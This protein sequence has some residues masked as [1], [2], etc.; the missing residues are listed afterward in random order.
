MTIEQQLN[1][2]W[3]QAV[4]NVESNAGNYFYDKELDVPVENGGSILLLFDLDADP[5]RNSIDSAIYF[6]TKSRSADDLVY[7]LKHPDGHDSNVLHSKE[8]FISRVTTVAND[9]YTL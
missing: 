7:A 5:T 1:T 9:W 3:K 8:D 6:S 4:E 2:I